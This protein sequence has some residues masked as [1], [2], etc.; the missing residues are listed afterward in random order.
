MK[1]NIVRWL[2]KLILLVLV[3]GFVARADQIIYIDSLQNGWQNWSWATVNLANPSPVHSG[4]DSISVTAEAYTAFY[5]HASA[6]FDPSG[7]TNLVFWINGGSAGGQL[8]QVQ[9]TLNGSSVNSGIPLA[10]LGK[11]SWQQINVPMSSLIPA[12]QTQMDGFWIQDATGTTQ[13]TFYVD[14]ITLQSVQPMPS[15]SVAPASLTILVGS[16]MVLTANATGIPPLSYQWQNSEGLIS[17]ASNTVLEIDDIQPTNADNYSVIVTNAY[18]SVTSA[19]ATVTVVF[20]AIISLQ[21]TN[22]IVAAGTSLTLVALASGTPPLNYE[23]QNSSG[24]IPNETNNSLVFEPCAYELHRQLFRGRFQSLQHSNESSCSRV[25]VFTGEY[26][27][28]TCKLDRSLC[29]SGKF[30]LSRLPV[31]R[32]QYRTSGF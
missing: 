28:S 24:P 15:V 2:C 16:N 11:N 19:V 3:G 5:L 22:Q 31:F 9:A 21:P 14:D 4:T 18:G 27:K 10:A 7:Y 1:L 8:L 6:A 20:P 32:R 26:F 13:P 17:G 30:F 25:R 12:G 23:W 29:H